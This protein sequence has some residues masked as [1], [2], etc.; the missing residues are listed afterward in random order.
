MATRQL[1]SVWLALLRPVTG[2]AKVD[3]K[4]T[5]VPSL[6]HFP[7][8]QIQ[9]KLPP[10]T[11]DSL[12]EALRECVIVFEPGSAQIPPLEQAKLATLASTLLA[13]GPSLGLV[14]GAHPDP[15]GPENAEKDISKARAEAVLSR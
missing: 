3:S 10:D 5:L 13:A 15:A 12:R 8:Y 6:Y 4:F 1:E 9:S 14:I 7:G 11:L 2:A